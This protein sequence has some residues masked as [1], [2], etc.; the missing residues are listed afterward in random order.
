ML[1]QGINCLEANLEI[2]VFAYPLQFLQLRSDL[3]LLLI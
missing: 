1:I 2:A 3:I